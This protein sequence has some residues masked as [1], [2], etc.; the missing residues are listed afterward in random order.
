[1]GPCPAMWLTVREASHEVPATIPIILGHFA[2]PAFY[3]DVPNYFWVNRVWQCILCT[4]MTEKNIGKYVERRTQASWCRKK[5]ICP[6]FGQ[7]TPRA[8]SRVDL[9]L[10]RTG[11]VTCVNVL[12][13][14]HSFCHEC[15]KWKVERK[16]NKGA[17]SHELLRNFEKIWVALNLCP[18][19]HWGG[20]YVSCCHFLEAII[21]RT[22]NLFVSRRHFP[23]CTG[24]WRR[25]PLILLT[26]EENVGVTC[27]ECK[28]Q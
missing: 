5:I 15:Y 16:R 2:F 25:G 8:V 7:S 27:G 23:C 17:L 11:L 4:T 1:M 9:L 6:C 24:Q 10:L 18:A 22:L 28:A 26:F 21:Q 20:K 13:D 19:L 12:Q 3:A 14:A